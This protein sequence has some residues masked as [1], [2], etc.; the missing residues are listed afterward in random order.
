MRRD[1]AIVLA[2]VL[3]L[4]TA[5]AANATPNAAPDGAPGAAPPKAQASIT[6]RAQVIAAGPG[7]AAVAAS[8]SLLSDAAIGATTTADGLARITWHADDAPGTP[9]LLIE[10]VAN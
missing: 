6:A 10:F 7:R 5:L 4:S 2:S 3:V 9:A 1:L 8:E